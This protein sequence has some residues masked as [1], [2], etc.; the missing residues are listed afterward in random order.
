MEF[1]LN[2]SFEITLDL[3]NVAKIVEYV[4]YTL[5][6]DS[7]NVHI[8]DNCGT[9][10]K[11]KKLTLVPFSELNCVLYLDFTGFSINVL[12]LFQD[13]IQGPTLYVTVVSP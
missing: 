2:F 5:H 10:I 11:T 12:L 13:P 7:P 8:L 4:Q 6:S 1:F 9:S 3:Q